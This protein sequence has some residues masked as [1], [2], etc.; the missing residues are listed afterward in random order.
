MG[1][2]LIESFEGIRLKAYP[3]QRGIPTDGYGHTA[4]VHLGDQITQAQAQAYLKE[5]CSVAVA[6]VNRNVK[7]PMTQNMFDALVSLCFNIGSGNFAN[8]TLVKLL[9]EGSKL[10]SIQFL[11]WDKVDGVADPG[12]LRRRKAEQALFLK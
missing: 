9:N 4:G 7:V 1:L 5:D 2:A 10:A 3:D 6:C 11:V 12:L 8:S